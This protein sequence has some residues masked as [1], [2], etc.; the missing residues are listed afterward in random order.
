MGSY[1]SSELTDIE[2][3]ELLKNFSETDQKFLLSLKSNRNVKIVNKILRDS[4]HKIKCKICARKYLRGET[5]PPNKHEYTL[6][7][8]PLCCK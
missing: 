7:A 1:V 3:N 6:Y 8:I 4:K 2:R 5:K